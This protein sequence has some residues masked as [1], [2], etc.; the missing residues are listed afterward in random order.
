MCA[1][2]AGRNPAQWSLACA[3]EVHSARGG[4]GGWAEGSVANSLREES[5]IPPE[6]PASALALPSPH[7]L[8]WAPSVVVVLFAS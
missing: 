1:Q 6:F 3:L 8:P 7:P 2:L 4:P 5:L